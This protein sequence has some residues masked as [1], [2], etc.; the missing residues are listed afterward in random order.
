MKCLSGAFTS[1]PLLRSPGLELGKSGPGAGL[2]CHYYS[3]GL[4]GDRRECDA[5]QVIANRCTGLT[6]LIRDIL[7]L[8]VYILILKLVAGGRSYATV[9]I[10]KIDPDVAD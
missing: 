3:Q 5:I 7:P 9:V 4:G 8:T 1:H 6:S 10:V 2:R